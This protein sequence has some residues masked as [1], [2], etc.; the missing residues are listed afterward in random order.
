MSVFPTRVQDLLDFSEQH[1]TVWLANATAIGISSSQ[2]TAFK[3]AALAA[4]TAWNAQIA[5][6]EARR[7]AVVTQQ[8]AVQALR[9]V[10]GDTVRLIRAFAEVQPSPETVYNL[11]QIPAP[12]APSPA[13]PPGTPE[14]F[15][16]TLNPGGSVTIR[17]KCK[18]PAGT[19]GTVYQVSRRI[20]GPAGAYVVVGAVGTKKFTDATIPAGAGVVDY[21][22]LGQ[23]A[24]FVGP[25]SSPFTVQFGQSG[26]QLTITAQYS[27]PTPTPTA[28]KNAA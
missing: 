22:V 26:E 11:A 18:N 15:K 24:E 12:A 8:S 27:T 23:R 9:G 28:L 20:G 1:A 3:A 5:A 4:R 21:I 10:G 17:W 13:G 2:A 14:N 7:I 25:A 16:A 6:E 19:T